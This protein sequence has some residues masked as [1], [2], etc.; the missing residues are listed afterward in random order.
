MYLGF[1]AGVNCVQENLDDF[2]KNSHVED[3]QFTCLEDIEEND[4]EEL[5]RKYDITLEK[6]SYIDIEEKDFTVRVMKK[7][8]KLNIFKVSSGNDVKNENDILL[9][10]V[11]MESNDL[12]MG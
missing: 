3:A 9:S 11:F 12:S 1:D 5:E 4:I 10:T 6:Q 7:N 2:Y 8:S